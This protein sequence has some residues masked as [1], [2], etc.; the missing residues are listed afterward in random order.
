VSYDSGDKEPKV[1]DVVEVYGQLWQLKAR[2]VFP[3]EGAPK[4]PGFA[5]VP[6]S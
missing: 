6:V 5:A 2:Q 1:G 4:D 3:A